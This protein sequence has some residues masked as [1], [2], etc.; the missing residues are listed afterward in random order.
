LNVYRVSDVRQIKIHTA[1]TLIPQ[2]SPFQVEI[3]IAKLKKYKLTGIDQI[4]AELI[5]T[6]GEK[7][8][9]ETRRLTNSI[10]SKE[11][12]PEKW[13]QSII[14]HIYKKGDKIGSNNY[15]GLSLLSASYKS[16][17]NILL[18]RLSPYADKTIGDY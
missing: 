15:G 13:K 10:L 5:Q 1:E 11:E 8:Y 12:L 3:G 2:P 4:P 17:S 6:G 16:L 18:S 7:L 14:V 9:S